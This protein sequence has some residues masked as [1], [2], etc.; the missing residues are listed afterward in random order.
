MKDLFWFL[1]EGFWSRFAQMV[2]SAMCNKGTQSCCLIYVLGNTIH[3]KPVQISSNKVDCGSF[4]RAFP[5]PSVYFAV[6]VLIGAL[7]SK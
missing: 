6:A 1:F 2:F 5:L 4:I 3:S 7:F